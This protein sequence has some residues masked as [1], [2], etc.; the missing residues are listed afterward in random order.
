MVLFEFLILHAQSPDKEENW[1]TATQASPG[2]GKSSFIDCIAT[3]TQ[4]QMIELTSG[5]SIKESDEDL[6][7][8]CQAM[9]T[10]IRVCV[11]Y[12]GFQEVSDFDLKHPVA[13]LALRMLH[14]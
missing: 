8:F 5:L 7:K 11:D 10:S 13:G 2:M 12:N 14:S 1:L 3:L 4:K 6:L 9:S